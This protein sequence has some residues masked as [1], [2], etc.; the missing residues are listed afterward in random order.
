MANYY[1]V[2]YYSILAVLIICLFIFL[3][4]LIQKKREEEKQRRKLELLSAQRRLE[5]ARE[6]LGILRK[7]LIEAEKQ[8]SENKFFFNS[9]KEDLIQLT[10]QIQDYEKERDSIQSTLSEGAVSA[11]E[12]NL[13]KKRQEMQ[14]ENITKLSG[15]VIE[16][17]EKVHIMEK[18]AM[19]NEIEV[20]SLQDK[21]AQAE[22]DLEYNKEMV[23]LKEKIVKS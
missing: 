21:I 12:T 6:T 1:S 11:Q 13:L 7:K 8:Y 17:Q 2:Y 20:A 16:L 5:E 3:V 18:A 10:K 14:Q 22:S 19:N 23:K 15:D 4:L 9:K